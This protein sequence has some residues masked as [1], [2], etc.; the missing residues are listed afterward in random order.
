MSPSNAS[1]RFDDYYT[2]GEAA[3]YLGV[4]P[5]TLRNWD[6]SG[7]LRPQRH[8]HN[9]YRIYLHE[10]LQTLLQSVG[11]PQES[12]S[13][14]G[15]THDDV[16]EGEHFVQFYEDDEYLL[17]S[18]HEYVAGALEAGQ[19]SIVVATEAHRTGLI[20][21]L[22]A[23]GLD[24]AEAMA[25]D[26]LVML[27]AGQTLA[28]FMVEGSPDP[29]QFE[30][31]VG[32]LVAGAC[33]RFGR[34]HA[35]GEMVALLWADG[36]RQA[37]IE[38]ESLW[39]DLGRQHRFRLFCAYP[40][41]GFESGDVA[42]F[43]GVCTCHSRVVPAE[44]YSDSVDTDE[45][46]RA[47]AFLQHRAQSL[48]A[49]I[50]HRREVQ[51]VL[52]QREKE[53]ADFF[54]NASEGIHKVGADGTVLWANR[55]EYELLGYKAEEYIGHS[56]RE[57]H[58][59]ADV[60]EDILAR[61][62]RGETLQNY[63]ARLRCKGGGIK[64]VLINSSACFEEGEFAYTRCFTRDVTQIWQAEQ[65][66]REA[67]RRKDEFLA[68]LAHELRNPLAPIGNALA[69]LRLSGVDEE[70][71][72]IMQRQLGQL[73]RL[74]DDLLDVS[75]ITRNKIELRKQMT[76]LASIIRSAVE[77]SRPLIDAQGHELRMQLPKEPVR[78]LADPTRLGQV[79]SNLLNNSAKYTPAGGRIELT[80]EVA[81]REVVVRV[82]DNG[83]GIAC[84][85]L[86]HVFDMF[87]QGD[88]SLER[89]Q[90]GLGIGLSL[91]QRLVVLHGGSV[92]AL[93]EGPGTGSEFVVR[94]PLAKPAE[95]ASNRGPADQ[96]P[97]SP[98]RKVLIADDNRDSGE[99]LA[100]LLRL[101]GHDVRTA[102]DGIE[103][104][105]V[106]EAFAPDVIL[107]DVGMPRLNGY[108]ATRRIRQTPWGKDATII[109]L[110]GWGQ[111]EDVQ[112][113]VEAGCTAHL[114]KPVNFAALDRLLAGAES[115]N[116]T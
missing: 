99:T 113:S 21:K 64:H 100:K 89:S 55:A 58:A 74:V 83:V 94:L 15:L 4:S 66:L 42:D 104:A 67:D 110:T 95:R 44:S 114:V 60:I 25:T 16:D 33:Q 69:A 43:E 2:V 103:A 46:L 38:L 14:G 108:D 23:A 52:S 101:K 116:A 65:A 9:G 19:A 30:R 71:L 98:P 80:A 57:F 28:Q 26:R 84:E 27:D 13:T 53:L 96:E 29:R 105:Q 11:P 34:V 12:G 5:A 59:D 31:S 22:A 63:A 68:T 3:K 54:E 61:L 17:D 102:R 24:V 73:T 56:I 111:A 91:V 48:E 87:R 97:K 32:S 88:G 40:I 37:A 115:A 92:T 78:L 82:R 85:S 6:R 72:S 50:E 41:G 77:T 81:G 8:P 75:R 45:R 79:F 112:R 76:D 20:T 51:T 35:F 49:E 39:N 106:A 36:N 93:S 1:P 7:K 86:P 109:A 70:S 62:G 47:I 18:L 10:D 107:M 90:G